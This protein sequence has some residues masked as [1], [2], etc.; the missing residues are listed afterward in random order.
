MIQCILRFTFN[1]GRHEAIEVRI[2]SPFVILV[3]INHS[4][5]NV[6]V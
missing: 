4:H 6:F 3:N 5:C 2:K 1:D